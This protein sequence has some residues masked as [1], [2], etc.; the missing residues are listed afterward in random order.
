MGLT[1]SISV[2]I[3]PSEPIGRTVE[4]FLGAGWTFPHDRVEYEC[5]AD[6]ADIGLHTWVVP[7]SDWPLVAD[8]LDTRYLAGDTVAVNLRHAAAEPVEWFGFRREDDDILDIHIVLSEPRLLLCGRFTDY[9]DYLPR[10]V[11]PLHN[12][13]YHILEVSTNDDNY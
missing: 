5:F 13:G 9:G 10:I 7:R 11:T 6:A 1:A 3:R 12:A 2:K 4:I 8:H